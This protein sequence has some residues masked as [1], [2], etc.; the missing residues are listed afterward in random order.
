MRL[1][2]YVVLAGA[3]VGAV[4]GMGRLGYDCFA[5]S[6]FIVPSRTGAEGPKA[7]ANQSKAATVATLSDQPSAPFAP[8]NSLATRDA[9]LKIPFND[10]GDTYVD[11]ATGFKRRIFGR[12][13]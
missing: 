2:V 10:T 6:N 1:I 7:G 11:P 3:L 4:G 9:N 13:R 5:G 8:K 12:N